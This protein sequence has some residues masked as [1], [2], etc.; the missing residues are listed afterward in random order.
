M[1]FMRSVLND[2]RNI[3]S[4]R[5]TGNAIHLSSGKKSIFTEG[6]HYSDVDENPYA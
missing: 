2:R 4:G 3:V 6:S 1:L 5:R